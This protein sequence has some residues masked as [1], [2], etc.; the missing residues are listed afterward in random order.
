[1][2]DQKKKQNLKNNTAN[3]FLMSMKIYVGDPIVRSVHEMVAIRMMLVLMD[4]GT[5]QNMLSLKRLLRVDRSSNASKDQ[6]LPDYALS[7]P[8][9]T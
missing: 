6:N 1:M 7:C 9:C 5:T 3:L 4:F 8:S 2:G